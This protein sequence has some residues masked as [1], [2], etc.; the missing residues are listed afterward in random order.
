MKETIRQLKTYAPL[1]FVALI[2]MVMFLITT[3]ELV[4]KLILQA[5]LA[6]TEIIFNWCMDTCD[7]LQI[8]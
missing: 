3:I 1:I 5:L 8:R 6:L 4:I 7:S 2:A